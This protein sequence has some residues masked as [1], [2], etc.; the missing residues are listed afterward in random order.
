[1]KR[2]GMVLGV[3]G[4]G[5]LATGCAT[6]K[7]VAKTVAPVEQRL[8]GTEGKNVDQDKQIAGQGS[9]IEDLDRS[10]SQTMKKVGDVDAK[11]TQ[12][13]E[14]AKAADQKA[15]NAQQDG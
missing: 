7:Y 12:A 13:G 4:L 6:K 10:L 5:L 15:G 11:A 1:M 14:A 3:L 9:Q 8:T 2:T